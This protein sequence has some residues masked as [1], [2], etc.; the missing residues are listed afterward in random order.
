[1]NI[2]I[3]PNSIKLFGSFINRRLSDQ[4]SIDK[5]AEALLNDLFN[6]A[7]TAFDNNGLSKERNK[8]I[9]LQHMSIVPQIVLKHMGDNPLLGDFA[10][11]NKIKEL[12][13]TVIKATADSSAESFQNLINN[14][15]GFIGNT[16]IIVSD[17]DPLDRFE[18]VSTEIYKTSNQEAIY[19]PEKGYSENILDP[20]KE[21]EFLISRAII[22]SNNNLAYR[23]RLGTL[24][25]ILNDESF[26]NTTGSDNPN[27]PILL[28][29]NDKDEIVKF[30]STGTESKD[31][32]SPVYTIKIDKDALRYQFEMI[33]RKNMAVDSSLSLLDA[34][35]MAQKEVDAFLGYINS[36]LAKIKSGTTVFFNIDA[37]NSSLGF[38]AQDR[39]NPTDLSKITNLNQG[40]TRLEQEYQGASFYPVIA[41][42]NTNK[43]IRVYEQALST[44]TDD[45]FEALHYLIT[46]DTLKIEGYSDE[47]ANKATTKRTRSTR[48]DFMNFFIDSYHAGNFHYYIQTNIVDGK[49][50]S[51]R[52]VRLGNKKPIAANKLT[53]QELKDFANTKWYKEVD[54]NKINPEESKPKASINDTT[55]IGEYFYGEDG[56][57]FEVFGVRRS[58]TN[59][60]KANM[61]T[62]IYRVPTKMVDG[63]LQRGERITIGEHVRNIGYTNIVPTGEGKLIGLGSYMVVKPGLEKT[64]DPT[65]LPKSIRK[66]RS[67]PSRNL[68]TLATDE[69]DKVAS[70]W[71]QNSPLKTVVGLNFINEASEFGPN[72]VA[73]FVNGAINLFKGSSSSDIYHESFHAFFDGILTESE[74]KEILDTLRKTPGYFN[75]VVNGVSK[76]VAYNDA[77]SIELEEFLAEGFRE[78]ALSDGKKSKFSDNK[79]LAFFQKLFNLLKSVFGNM[80]YAEAR[81]LNKSHAITDAIFSDLFNGNFTA[82]MFAPISQDAKWS[83]SEIETVTGDKFSLE[84]MNSTMTGMRSILSDFITQGL[85]VSQNAEDQQLAV[86]YLF[87]MSEHPVGSVQYNEAGKLLNQLEEGGTIRSGAGVFNLAT[88]PQLLGIAVEYI[89]T[90]FEQQLKITNAELDLINAI[91]SK[92]EKEE[93]QSKSLIYKKQLLDKIL[94]PENFGKLSDLNVSEIVSKD[95]EAVV[96]K[97]LVQ[98]FLKNYSNLVLKKAAYEDTY[99]NRA[100][101]EENY[102]PQWDR[103]GNDQLF[104]ELIDEHTKNILD[105]IHAYTEQGKG[106][107][108]INPVLGFKE[109]LPFKNALAKVAKVLRNT[110]DAMEMCK[111]LK[112]AAQTDKEMD[113]IFRKLG[114]ISDV[115]FSENMSSVEHKQWSEFWQTFN[116]ADVLLREFIMERNIDETGLEEPVVTHISKSGK[117]SSV[118]LQVTRGWAAN[119]KFK[120]FNSPF[121]EE[122]NGI[123]NMNVEDLYSDYHHEV[124]GVQEKYYAKIDGVGPNIIKS[125]TDPRKGKNDIYTTTAL[126]LAEADP[127]AFLAELGIDLIDDA[128]VRRIL[129][130]G[131]E[132]L[133]I[134][135]GLVKY[136]AE[137][138]NNRKNKV[139]W[140]STTELYI[141][142]PKGSLISNFDDIFKSFNYLD[143]KGKIQTQPDLFGYLK[144]LRELHYAYSDEYTNFSSY[145]ASGELQSEKSFNSSLL[146]QVSALNLADSLD[147]LLDVK[148]MEHLDPYNN[149]QAAACKWL[150]DM[151]QLDPSVHALN[152]RG[153][154]DWSI[155]ISVENLSGSKIIEK[156]KGVKEI[157]NRETGDVTEERQNY[158]IDNG[159]ESIKS[160]A[161]TKFITDFHLTLE[162]KQEIMRSEAKS[163]SYTAYA[164]SRKGSE[165]R[166]GL[167][168]LIN[169]FEIEQIYGEKYKGKLLYAEFKNHIAAE[170]IRIQNVKKLKAMILNKEINSEDL[171]IDVKQLNRG[172]DWFMFDKIFTPE[173]KQEL[174]KVSLSGVLANNSFT[175]DQLSNDVKLEI[176]KQLA[177][178]FKDEAQTLRNEKDSKLLISDNLLAEYSNKDE[179]IDSVKD[180]MYRAFVINNFVQNANYSSLF[181]GDVTVHDVVGE[182][183]HKRIAGLIS[184]GKIFRHDDTWLHFINS[185]KYNSKGFAKKHNAAKDIQLD[186]SFNGYLNTAI[187][188]EARSN[189]IYSKHYRDLFDVDTEKYDSEEGAMEEAD[190]QGYISFDMY[191]ILNE[192]IGEWSEGQEKVYQK[193]LNGE[194]LS[195]ADMVAT[196]PARKFQYFGTV[197]NTRTQKLLDSMGLTFQNTAFHKYSLIPLI[198]ALIKDT[199]LETMHEKMMEQNIDY[200]TMQS[201]SKLSTLTK[202]EVVD[203]KIKAAPDDFYNASTRTITNDPD[204]KFTPNV[205]HVK[206]LKSQI[207]L[208]EGYKGHITLPTQLRK[209]ALIGVMDGGIPTD[210]KYTGKKDIKEAW[211]SLSASDKLKKSAKWKWLQEYNDTLGEI[212]TVLKN[213]LLEDMELK[214]STVNG[215]KQYV[216]DSSRLVKYLQD[217]LKSKELLP[218]E[219]AYIAKPDGTLIDDLSLSLIS[220]KLEEL[221]VTMVDKQLRRI[222]VNG[223]ALVQVSGAMYENK[224]KKPNLEQLEKFGTNGLKFYYLKNEDG[225]IATDTE[226]NKL[227]QEMEVKIS[228]QGDFKKLLYTTHPDGKQIAI[229]TELEE[230]KRELDYEGSLA[231]LN[232]AIKD[233][234]WLNEYSKLISIPGVRIPTQGPNALV[235]ATV[236]EFLPEWAGPIII[237]PSEI[238][239]QSG[240][241]YDIDKLFSIFKNLIVFNNK[242]EEVVYDSSVTESYDQLRESLLPINEKLKRAGEQ[243]NVAWKEYTDYLEDK[244]TVNAEVAD[245]YDT[246]NKIQEEINEQYNYK[247][248]ITENSAYPKE[249]KRKLSAE[250]EAEIEAS[251]RSINTVRELIKNELERFFDAE[252]SSNDVRKKLVGENYKKYMAVINGITDTIADL[253]A[254]SEVINRK[255]AGKGVKGLENKLANLLS[256]KILMADNLKLLVTPNTIKDVEP[257]SRIA[258]RLIKKSYNKLANKNNSTSKADE[259]SKTSIFE[260]RYNL[261]KHQENSV[262]IDSLGIAAIASTFYALFTTFGATLQETTA[263][264]QKEFEDALLLIQD[265]SKKNTAAYVKAMSTIESF[266]NKKLNFK[267]DTGELGYNLNT[268]ANAL[269]LGMMKNVD[270]KQISDIL[271]QLI[272]GY[273]DVAKDAWIFDTQ[274]TKENTPTLLFMVMA[275][276]SVD[277]II[278]MVNNPLVLEFNNNKKELEGVFAT[279][280][281]IEVSEGETMKVSKGITVG[282]KYETA[283]QLIEQK[284][285]DLFI[286]SEEN[287]LNISSLNINLIGNSA[288][289]FSNIELKNR[290]GKDPSFKDIQILAHYLQI[291]KMASALNEF[292]Q[293]SKFDTTKISNISEAQDRI[294]DIAEFK[295]TKIENKI[296]PDSWFADLDKSPVGKFNQDKFIVGLF[297]QYFKIRNNKALVLR[298]LDIKPPKGTDRRK[299]LGDFKNDFMWFL[300]QNAVYGTNTYTTSPTKFVGK[301]KKIAIPGKT[302]TLVKDASLETSFEINNE[303][304]EVRY[305]PIAKTIDNNIIEFIYSAPFFNTDTP[306]EWVKFRLEFDNL[307]EASKDLSDVEF[308]EKYYQFDNAGKSFLN[309]GSKEGRSIIL[310]RAAL[311]NTNNVKAMFD[312][313]A[314]IGFIAK[315]MVSKYPDLKNYAFFRDMGFDFNEQLK[316]MNIYF[317][318]I[319]DVQLASVYRENIAQLKNHPSPEVSEFIGKIT[320]IA[321]MQ[322]GMNRSSK[323]DISKITDQNLFSDVIQAEI[324]LPYI[325]DVLDQLAKQFENKESRKDGQIIDQFKELYKKAIAGNGMRIKVRG[326][327][328][329]VDKLDFSKEKGLKKSDIAYS[330]ITIVP[331]DKTIETDKQE[332]LISYFYNN[333]NESPVDFAKSI[334]DMPWVIRNKKIIAPEGKNQKELDKAL[335]VLGIDNSKELPALKYKSKNVKK[336][337]L[338]IAESEVIKDRYAIKDDAM[339]NSSTKAIGQGTTKDSKGV[340]FNPKYQ[341]SSD[342]YAKALDKVY[343]DKRAKA[344]STKEQFVST[345]KVWVFGSMITPRAYQGRNEAEFVTAVKKTFESYHKPLIMKA[346]DAGV[347]TFYVGTA[348]GIDAMTLELLKEF[349]YV[350]V[351]KY[352]KVGTYYEVV[353]T[354]LVNEV[355][356]QNFDP[357]KPLVKTKSIKQFNQLFDEIYENEKGKTPT[358]FTELTNSELINSGLSLVESK[359]KEA[360]VK[361][362]SDFKSK[363]MV[364]FRFNFINA[365]NNNGSGRIEIGNSLFDSMVEQVLMK[366][367]DAVFVSNAKLNTG[368]APVK[369]VKS[370]AQNIYE[371][372]GY[373]TKSENVVLPSDLD[374]NT[375]YTGKN[376]WNDIVPEA[377][378]LFDNK[379]NRKTGK[380][381]TMLIAFRG[382]SKKSFLQNYKDGLTLG[383]PFDWQQESGSRDEAGKISTIKFIHWMTTGENL[384][385]ANAT[386]EY[387]QAII[388]DIALGK[389]KD[390][391]IL[392]YQEKG[393]AT[394]ATALD[395]LINQYDW[396]TPTIQTPT[397]LPKSETKINI[398]AS[399]GENASLSNFAERP[400]SNALG[401]DFRNVE[402]AFQ[403]AKI[404]WSTGDNSDIAMKLQTASGSEAQSL[405]KKIKGLDTKAWDKNSSA[406]M[407]NIIKESFQENPKALAKLLATGS[408][409]LTHTQDKTKWGSEFPKL[410]MEVRD[411]LGDNKS[412]TSVG[413]YT[414]GTLPFTADQKQTILVNFANKYMKGKSTSEA[415]K[416]IEEALEARDEQG[417]K[418]I[419]ELLKECYK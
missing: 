110:P 337:F 214:E 135:P 76:L 271:S 267:T 154:R 24:S 90:R 113:Q 316:K 363:N 47:S 124:D 98:V 211:D 37:A 387:R 78:Y 181:L 250:I 264:K 108:K 80:S 121:I 131:D 256:E 160:D 380:L 111:K 218:E 287:P 52:M 310:Q 177:K 43:R 331:L 206:Y 268:E 234:T 328:Y 186:Y 353:P 217:K 231:R 203:G 371:Q 63:V 115:R 245:K 225:S 419:I 107:V 336:G 62:I 409:T 36:S 102:V 349:R 377:R 157:I 140:D 410:L 279:L 270:Q 119:F 230:G 189:S 292:T 385:N 67:L 64:L 163:T 355:E 397:N 252:I 23:L 171:A 408:A 243:L 97:T 34:K 117:S 176:E 71:W 105:S 74:R 348:S 205:L 45:E 227:V 147:A 30:D 48:E 314:G 172:G 65:A 112:A 60:K 346:L 334:K 190:G 315:N 31:G 339:A 13:G 351:I 199:H 347:N 152:K 324:G 322:T 414:Y 103:S 298:S 202:V 356:G 242:V 91:E 318:Q 272:N 185:E 249:L 226:G 260:Y 106:V 9:V 87:Q 237:L 382:N 66:W 265:S 138:L 376:F 352:T 29:V 40:T 383:N 274:G 280:G 68:A 25:E 372:L 286:M 283:V 200:V 61:D 84:E 327:D 343:P 299:I 69:Q 304:G 406:I 213:Q 379:M 381:K 33:T 212:E 401:V 395:Y 86:D 393:Y 42:E 141:K 169:K 309:K 415:Q 56:K 294:E 277:A 165:T 350:P 368:V 3:T 373:K 158:E 166:K 21:F 236:A 11:F 41:V 180:K 248:Q 2:C 281:N 303:T 216:G 28:L 404:N 126:S 73:N 100:I 193:M 156:Y 253:N 144:Q 145:N 360:I 204:F 51:E 136:I 359:I 342:G 220:E 155:K 96:D 229:Y 323:Y 416:Y 12:A 333:P 178:Y 201:G 254:Q 195:K 101:E 325:N 4:L 122:N 183:F 26:V 344:K 275:G 338:S 300:Y 370:A 361:L 89:K 391:S 366:F 291:E 241:D 210:F 139:L 14:F 319:K 81:A 394:H 251:K 413:K 79:I 57:V 142:D 388:N 192:S 307:K 22:K 18:A 109:M 244:S 10:S 403:Y 330:N 164:S 290:V 161:K 285:K 153:K 104:D 261:S 357:A 257:E 191:R 20:K 276:V 123:P 288:P 151:F 326:T 365:L 399:T 7:L 1:M 75:T 99:D 159:I 263:E 116:K 390:S 198:P 179:S 114:D 95:D 362:D 162:G 82:E 35:K 53:L 184:T 308:K 44:L 313:S 293:L 412:S 27:L 301:K 369:Q 417:Q 305:S 208:A 392:Y 262:G 215:N 130:T 306:K 132:Q 175:I 374:V 341:S 321:I 378:D 247:K 146:N 235:S 389:I 317:P 364:G 118:S 137:S 70:D 297:A 170:M 16:S 402:A 196:F 39:N 85:N 187:I 209:I 282:R 411:E 354:G 311:Y 398:Y 340:I 269:A 396:S 173:L 148:G 219:I 59:S 221:L 405:G 224:F 367:R 6:D 88:N 134:D 5:T 127:F 93:S 329:V 335:L 255:I 386:E 188:K 239:A 120:L 168:L 92:T 50:V 375:T 240:A 266:N 149:P 223:E 143:N 418:E 312:L 302:H 49:E 182:A 167:N 129:F 295:L 284:Y 233:K 384:G 222:S 345:D 58:F 125:K 358:W 278:N 232:E 15:G 83:S 77:T 197:S 207:F 8:E 32:L 174:E 128:D 407:K 246:I 273:V 150:I 133:G 320:H 228:L 258:G 296:I 400:V 19:T 38:I 194:T 94:K 55:Y 72:F 54:K 259:I 17:F 332:L 46:A 289:S 238:V